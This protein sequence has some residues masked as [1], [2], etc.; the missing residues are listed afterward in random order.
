M[1]IFIGGIDLWDGWDDSAPYSR[2]DPD[3][4]RA[5]DCGG[6]CRLAGVRGRTTSSICLDF[7]ACEG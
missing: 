1:K 3:C 5:G 6:R 7:I 4:A 2:Y